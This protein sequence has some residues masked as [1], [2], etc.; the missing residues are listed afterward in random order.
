MWT[1]PEFYGHGTRLCAGTVRRMV[2][3]FYDIYDSQFC[4]LVTCTWDKQQ[5]SF[6][7]HSYTSTDSA[8]DNRCM[9]W[10]I[11]V[12]SRMTVCVTVQHWNILMSYK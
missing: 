10:A 12:I 8:A 3:L 7:E 4:L 5:A 6:I 1:V 2:N 11:H 9:F